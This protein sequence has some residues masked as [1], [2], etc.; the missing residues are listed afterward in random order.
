MKPVELQAPNA[1]AE[2]LLALPKVELHRHLEGALRLSTLVDIARQHRFE[3]PEYEL[4]T[5]RPFVQMMPDETR[6][7][8]HF[9][10]K[11]A[12]LRQF[13]LSPD[14]V[15]RITYEAVEDA[16]RDNIKYL[17]LRFTP[18]TLGKIIKAKPAKVIEWVCA[19]AA[20]AEADFDIA[21]RLIVSV[22][23]HETPALG[24]DVLKA[25][26]KRADARIVGFDLAGVE[27]GYSATL[28]APLF[29]KAKAAGL[30][31]TVHA[32]EWEGAQ[33]VW[34]AIS[35]LG[36]DRIGHGIRALEDPGVVNVLAEREITLE[37]CPTSNYFTGVVAALPL[38]PLPRLIASGVRTTLN[39][40]DPLI[41]NL[42]LTGELLAVV[43]HLGLEVDELKRAMLRAAEA[44]FLPADERAALVERFRM[45]L[46]IPA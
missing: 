33:S 39:T 18:R 22:N 5:L 45:L 12:T 2:T 35:S 21:A 15:H 38:H 29:H 11:F 19:A 28:F 30:G 1:L 27:E 44:A 31:I 46:A 23:R 37:V 26:L 40:D 13:Y 16:A 14:I 17:E 10:G 25:V 6:D 7:W 34:D 8:K 32:G 3:M 43:T 41:F 20:E 42:T 36:A 24:N 4:E 9:F